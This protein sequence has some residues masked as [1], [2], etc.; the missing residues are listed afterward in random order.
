MKKRALIGLVTVSLILAGAV[1]WTRDAA[2]KKTEAHF[3]HDVHDWM[4]EVELV[5]IY[6]EDS[7]EHPDFDKIWNKTD[8]LH[9]VDEMRL[10][11]A[12][13]PHPKY[14]LKFPRIEVELSDGSSV[15]EPFGIYLALQKDRGWVVLPVP[16][17][18]DWRAY[19]LTPQ[20]CRALKKQIFALKEN[21]DGELV[22]P[23]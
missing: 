9:A 6:A 3:R 1:F 8:L 20:T 14:G 21:S 15:G 19:D 11:R 4:K 12:P 22:L 2:W 16:P 7:K 10:M 17:H 13:S 23:R 5:H 18:Q